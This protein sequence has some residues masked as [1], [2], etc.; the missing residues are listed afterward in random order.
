M[1]SLSDSLTDIDGAFVILGQEGP[2]AEL[3]LITD[4]LGTFHAYYTIVDGVVLA[5]TSSLL[6]AT[7]VDPEW[8]PNGCREFLA[9][10]TLFE[11]RTLFRNIHKLQAATIYQFQRDG[12]IVANSY[13]NLASSLYQ[14]GPRSARSL[15]DVATAVVDA[16]AQLLRLYPHP[17]LD[18]TGGF[19]SRIVLGAALKCGAGFDTTVTGDDDSEDVA[20]SKKLASIYGLKHH[21]LKPRELTPSEHWVRAKSAVSLC[22]GE[23]DVAEYGRTFW[24]HDHLSDVYDA[25]INGSNGEICK[26]YW[27][28]LLFPFT[29]RAGHFDPLKIARA[30]FTF[31]GD[32]RRLLA[33]RFPM[34]LD[35]WFAD[36]IAR[37]NRGLEQYPNT[38]QLDHVYLRLR[39]QCWQGRI[40]SATGRIWPVWSPFS[41]RRPIEAAVASA[42]GVRVRHRLS[43]RLLEHFDPRLAAVQLADEGPAKPLRLTTAHEF[44]PHWADFV[45]SRRNRIL[46]RFGGGQRTVPTAPAPP[47]WL[48]SIEEARQ[49]L[50][51]AAM[52]TRGIYDPSNLAALL[53][54][55]APA[56]GVHAKRMQRVL[57]LEL[58]ARTVRSAREAIHA[59]R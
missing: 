43:R 29:G 1:R 6:L 21:Q 28:E 7:M 37:T 36:V 34:G 47:H 50:Q 55:D 54:T 15:D 38:S 26:G 41:F 27:W 11:S 10:G 56:S 53:R 46:K 33:E 16:V 39:M 12:E 59:A 49:M 57:T 25:S 18:L 9:M 13:W 24:V 42:P 8:D 32:V 20:V 58:L 17:V 40:A 52:L 23:C 48:W 31:E 19:D 4:R 45:W 44:I 51:P 30:R 22:D 35:E 5:S 14:G 2:E 3:T